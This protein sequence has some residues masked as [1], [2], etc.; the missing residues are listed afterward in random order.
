MI[1]SSLSDS[2]DLGT[3]RYVDISDLGSTRV[4]EVLYVEYGEGA[5][6]IFVLLL[7]FFCFGYS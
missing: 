1:V 7:N 3:R 6:V 5:A 2:V 4:R